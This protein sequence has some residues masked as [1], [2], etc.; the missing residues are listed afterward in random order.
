[1]SHDLQDK[2]IV[3]TGAGGG[4]G[5]ATC[6]MLAARG[7][8]IS[9]SGLRPQPL[10]DLAAEIEASGGQAMAQRVDVRDDAQVNDWIAQTVARF[11][12][13]DGAVN[14]AGA[15]PSSFFADTVENHGN[16]TWE[17]IIATNLTGT[18]YCMRAQLKNMRDGGSII[19]CGSTAS[20]QGEPGCSAYVA[21]KHGVVGLTKSAA[22][23]VGPTR[24]I[25]VNCI[26]P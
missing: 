2:V 18:M 16:G 13:L 7:A 14:L 22:K 23:E 26:A 10:Q 17:H 9:M 15:I 20:V 5:L 19:T 3:I 12:K 24:N 1:M 21:A 6:K 11:G 25:R 8:K 4:M